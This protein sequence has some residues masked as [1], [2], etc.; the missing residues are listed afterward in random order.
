MRTRSSDTH[1]DAE[2][3]QIALLRQASVAQRIRLVRSLSRTTMQLAKRA[4]RRANPHASEEELDLIFVSVHYG[5][6]LA[7]RL[8]EYLAKNRP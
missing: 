4:I 7:D 6:E 2:A 1:P 3:V 5:Q 8:L